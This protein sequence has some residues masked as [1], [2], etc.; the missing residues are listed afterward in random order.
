M[1]EQVPD[2]NIKGKSAVQGVNPLPKTQEAKSGEIGSLIRET[3]FSL[4]SV[5]EML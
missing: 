2:Y 3:Q 1:S 5:E 4:S